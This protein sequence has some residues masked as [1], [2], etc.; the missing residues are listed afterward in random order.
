LQCNNELEII[1]IEKRFLKSKPVCKVRFEL[2]AEIAKDA[3]KVSVVGNFNNWNPKETTLK[4]LKS[5]AFS[6]QV[7]LERD[8]KI[9]Y[10]YL[11]NESK[12]ENDNAAEAYEP[13]GVSYEENSVLFT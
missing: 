13:T 2:P 9:I 8:Q 12:W 5:G 6:G 4:K 1:S 10:R 3:K 7:N 11:I